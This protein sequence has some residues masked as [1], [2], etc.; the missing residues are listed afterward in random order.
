MPHLY[1]NAVENHVRPPPGGMT[2]SHTDGLTFDDV[3]SSSSPGSVLL[4]ALNLPFPISYS[5]FLSL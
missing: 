2:P 1:Q 5:P 3:W 4:L